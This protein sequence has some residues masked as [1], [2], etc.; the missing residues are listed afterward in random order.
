MVE[1][2][3]EFDAVTRCNGEWMEKVSRTK[4]WGSAL[5]FSVSVTILELYGHDDVPI[6][7]GQWTRAGVTRL[8]P[9]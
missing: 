4:E 8:K 1:E 7:I 2:E 3:K 5:S 9:F 6:P